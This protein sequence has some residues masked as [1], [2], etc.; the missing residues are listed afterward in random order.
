MCRPD[1]LLPESQAAPVVTVPA[2]PLPE[3]SATEVPVPSSMAQDSFR[4]VV[5]APPA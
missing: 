5:T 4:P 3:V 2:M 1:P